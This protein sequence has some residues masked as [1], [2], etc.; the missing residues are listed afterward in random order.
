VA[1]LEEL[2]EVMDELAETP[3][4]EAKATSMRLPVALQRATALAVELGMDE[5]VT[6]AM[7]NALLERVQAFARREALAAHFA[8]FPADVP[9]L[10][11]VV[12]RRI[13]GLDHPAAQRPDL[14][15]LAVA[16][17]EHRWGRWTVTGSVDDA[18]DLVLVLVE[19]LAAS[20]PLQVSTRTAGHP[21]RGSV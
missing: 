21:A 3:R 4:R 8:A 19:V 2:L 12:A 16:H 1:T 17:A 20:T 6:A 10:G 7:S 5:S 9:A 14:V 11:D 13:D 15:E 18:V